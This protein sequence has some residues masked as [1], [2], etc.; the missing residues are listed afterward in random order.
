M[1]KED[2]MQNGKAVAKEERLKH[3]MRRFLRLKNSMEKV[4]S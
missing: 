4:L 3:W 2:K 1:G